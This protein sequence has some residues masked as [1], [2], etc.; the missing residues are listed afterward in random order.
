MLGR[1]GKK[2]IWNLNKSILLLIMIG[3]TGLL[4]LLVALDLQLILSYQKTREKEEL[5]IVQNYT[6]KVKPHFYLNGL[7]TLN[8]LVLEKNTEKMQNLILN[9]S[10]H[11]RYLLQSERELVSL[12]EEIEFTENYVE[13]Q[14]NITG[15]MLECTITADLELETWQIPVLAIQTFVENSVKYAKVGSGQIP[16][17][18]TVRAEH[19]TADEKEYLDLTITDNGQ[20]IAC[21]DNYGVNGVNGMLRTVILDKWAVANSY[22][23]LCYAIN[24]NSKDKDT[25]CCMNSVQHHRNAWKR[26]N[27]KFRRKSMPCA[28]RA[29]KSKWN[30]WACARE[31]DRSTKRSW[32]SSPHI[33]LM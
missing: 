14:K 7:K 17:K 29:A 9:L 5:G 30:C 2:R 20:A 16:L 28:A 4:V 25:A 18:I 10:A 3:Y 23:E 15:R 27:R 13:M 19:L 33:R 11:L 26:W 22:A 32:K 24:T 31:M 6:D 8:V 12:K 21:L 1:T